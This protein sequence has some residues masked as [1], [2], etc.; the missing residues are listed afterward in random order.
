MLRRFLSY[1]RP[2]TG[3]LVLDIVCAVLSGLLE[4]GFPMAVRAFVDQLLPTQD[5]PLIV[6]ATV[7]LLAIYMANGGLMAI[8]TYW[9]HMLGVNIETE[10]IGRAHV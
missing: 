6:A 10:K 9:G 3:L 2:F 5:W 4:L 8:V 7:A 1:Y